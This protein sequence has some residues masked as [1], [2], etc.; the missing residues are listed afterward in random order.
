MVLIT[1]HPW[2]TLYM[3]VLQP[4]IGLYPGKLAVGNTV[5]Q[6]VISPPDLH[7]FLVTVMKYPEKGDGKNQGLILAHLFGS[8]IWGVLSGRE[9]HGSRNW[10]QLVQWHT[11]TRRREQ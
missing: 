1:P 2:A 9:R 5:S 6:D 10:R 4:V 7:S 11:Q 8:R 3:V